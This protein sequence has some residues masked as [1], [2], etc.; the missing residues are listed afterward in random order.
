MN[1]T[2]FALGSRGDVQP[3]IALAVALQKNGHNI[4]LCSYATFANLAAQYN[5]PFAPMSGD[6]TKILQSA[7]G[8]SMLRSNN[9]LKLLRTICNELRE[10]FAVMKEDALRIIKECNLIISVGV[11][12]YV[13]TPIAE[14]KGIPHI[15]VNLQPLLVTREF[16][17]ALMPP[18]FIRNGTVNWLTHRVSEQL[19]WEMLRPFTNQICIELGLPKRPRLWPISKAV[20][21]GET[22]LY[23][24]SRHVVPKP[25]DWPENAHVTGYFFLDSAEQTGDIGW[26]PQQSLLD[27]LDAGPPPVC[28]GFG[29][30]NTQ[31]PEETADLALRA[32]ELSGRR[33]I[34]LTGWGGLTAENVPET[35]YVLERAPHDWLFPHMAAVVHHGGAGTTAAGLRAGIPSILTPFFADQPFWGHYIEKLGVGPRPVP[36]KAL[37]ASKLAAAMT[38]AVTDDGM[39]MR[40]EEF[41][42]RIRAENGLQSACDIIEQ[43][44]EIIS[45]SF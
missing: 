27:F 9:P 32:L 42:T 29:S 4:T 45:C 7:D 28:I 21:S 31:S 33:G 24:Y 25:A 39:R 30:M 2:I 3:G 20:H 15:Q 16:P 13:T 26:Q 36:H 6:I 23:A 35:V 10:N 14:S 43:K 40:A 12:Y 8:Q 18:P 41:G 5:I 1:I 11:P 38:Q 34:L 37:T 22:V 17:N 19:F 44:L